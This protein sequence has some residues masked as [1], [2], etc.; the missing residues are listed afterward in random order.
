VFTT[1]WTGCTSINESFG[2]VRLAVGEG[3]GSGRR[4]GSEAGVP[5]VGFC[6][7]LPV[8]RGLVDWAWSVAAASRK[9]T[10]T[11]KKR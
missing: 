3:A 11:L 10:P 9:I 8:R 7:V 2:L 5:V 6:V 1:G 4:S